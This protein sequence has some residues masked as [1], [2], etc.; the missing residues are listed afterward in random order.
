[1]RYPDFSSIHKM[2]YQLD[3]YAGL[4]A[5]SGGEE[6]AA[7]TITA[8][9]EQV[10]QAMQQLAGFTIA[11]ELAAAEP[12]MLEQIL[13]CAPQNPPACAPVN[14]ALLRDK[15]K[16]AVLGRCIGCTLGVPVENW[17]VERMER[18]AQ[19]TGTPFP[20][21]EYWH[22]VTDPSTLQYNGSPRSA[23]TK[24]G[25]DGV[26]VDDDIT[27]TLLGLLILEEYRFGFTT[28]QVGRL[29]QKLLPV[30]CTAE[31][32]ALNNL[33]AGI[34]AAQAGEINNPYVQWIGADIRA[35]GFG[36]AAAGNPLLAAKLGYA[37][38]YLSHRRN[39][40]Y[41][42]MYFAAVIAAAFSAGTML[43]ALQ[44]GLWYIPAECALTKDI[45]WA[46]ETAPSLQN[47]REARAKVDERFA[48]MNNVHTNNNAC[49]T[50]FALLLGGDDFTKMI[51]ELVA[52]G[53]DNDCTAATAGSIFGALYGTAAIPAYWYANFNNAIYSYLKG[54][55]KFALEDV[56]DRFCKLAESQPK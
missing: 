8:V 28:E 50:L 41:G 44:A 53:L 39:G 23:Y 27:Y 52:M 22:A 35:D 24:S 32:V 3:A 43:E 1:M 25:M 26:P 47:W 51:S 30:A 21:T 15:M 42:E 11:P 55:E 13:A 7:Q 56:V 46:L 4:V 6:L 20:P 14:P 36:Y 34:P 18:F 40:I 37:D 48:G 49:L 16:A 29:W 54:Y 2:L 33:N 12:D 19:E 5:E 10:R 38:A 9:E 31:E 45:R 17:S